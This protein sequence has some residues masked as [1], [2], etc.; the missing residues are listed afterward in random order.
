MAVCLGAMTLAFRPSAVT[1]GADF[2]REARS[3]ATVSHVATPDVPWKST[4]HKLGLRRSSEQAK[5]VLFS[6]GTT[7]CGRVDVGDAAPDARDSFYQHP[8][9]LPRA[10]RGPPALGS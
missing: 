10:P 8:R 7:I 1:P 2:L 6:P 9:L 3:N 5:Q 4:S